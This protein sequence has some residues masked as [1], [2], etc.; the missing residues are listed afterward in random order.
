MKLYGISGL[1]ADQRVFQYLDLP[2]AI[3]PI[4]WI[5]PIKSETLISYAGRLTKQIDTEEAFAILGV[6]FGGLIAVEMSKL[7]NPAYLI[8]ISSAETSSDL[9]WSYRLL[10]KLK[11][12]NL[13]P[14]FFFNPPRFLANWV[15]QA[16]D[17]K[18]LS[19]ILDD[20]DTKFAKWCVNALISWKNEKPIEIR[21][22]KIGSIKDKLIPAKKQNNIYLIDGGGHFMVVDKADQLSEVIRSFI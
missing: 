14:H 22:L 17:K 8:L 11:I 9:R 3:T 18:L 6:S 2:L 21:H 20:T 13:V 5:D 16:T 4:D 12:L 15:F 1:G 7:I 19:A 10:G